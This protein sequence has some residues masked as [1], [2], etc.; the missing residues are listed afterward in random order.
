MKQVFTIIFAFLFISSVFAQNQYAEQ[1]KKELETTTG[2]A[3]ID[4]LHKIAEGYMKKRVTTVTTDVDGK[5]VSRE[6]TVDYPDIEQANKYIDE[7]MKLSKT[8]N[9]DSGLVVSHY[10]KAKYYTQKNNTEGAKQEYQNWMNV[11]TKQDDFKKIRWAYF[12]S[13]EYFISVKEFKLALKLYDE[14]SQIASKQALKP[15]EELDFLVSQHFALYDF[16]DYEKDKVY[17]KKIEVLEKEAIHLLNNRSLI[18]TTPY[19][20]L[21]YFFAAQIENALRGNEFQK[22][23]KLGNDWLASLERVADK[24]KQYYTARF[25]ARYFYDKSITSNHDV[26]AFM[27]RFLKKSIEYAIQTTNT[28]KITAAHYNACYCIRSTGLRLE[29]LELLIKGKNHFVSDYDKQRY[30]QALKACGNSLYYADKEERQKGVQA[31][32]RFKFTLSINDW[33]LRDFCDDYIMQLNR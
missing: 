26:K 29:A 4:L 32:Q 18:S 2:I 10:F 6:V 22:A 9:Y 7:A 19:V 1:L 25:I 27:T 15:Y 17:Q 23:E 3:R 21:D 30:V 8:S 11:R 16:R 14:L 20:T 24:E 12:N 33:E 28:K 31:L 13:I 5:I